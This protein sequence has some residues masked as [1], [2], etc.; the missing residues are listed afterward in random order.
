MKKPSPAAQ[1]G[2]SRP[3]PAHRG[4]RSLGVHFPRAVRIEPAGEGR[5]RRAEMAP[6]RGKPLHQRGVGRLLG[7]QKVTPSIGGRPAGKEMALKPREKRSLV[8]RE[9][10]RACENGGS[11]PG[12]PCRSNGK[13]RVRPAVGMLETSCSLKA[14]VGRAGISTPMTDIFEPDH[15][16]LA[17]LAIDRH[18]RPIAPQKRSSASRLNW[19][20]PRRPAASRLR[21]MKSRNWEGK[22]SLFIAPYHRGVGT[23]HRQKGTG[24]AAD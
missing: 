14:L 24:L 18:R 13:Q 4:Q 21:S 15:S 9:G 6:H 12:P 22:E 23:S 20:Q 8:K 1:S 16:P 11:A 7:C 2:R 19:L 5:I 3:P 10:F 17:K